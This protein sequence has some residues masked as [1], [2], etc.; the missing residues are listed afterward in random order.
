M[1]KMSKRINVASDN[2]SLPFRLQSAQTLF[3]GRFTSSRS[4]LVNLS[5]VALSCLDMAVERCRS[6]V[7]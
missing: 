6:L 3:S 5:V 4:V 1:D 7:P 2:E